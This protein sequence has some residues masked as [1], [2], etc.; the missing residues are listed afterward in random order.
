MTMEMIL[1]QLDSISACS[2]YEV[3]DNYI[4]LTI[5]DFAGF[6]SNW[7]EVYYS[8]A[9]DDAIDEVI[10]WL[11]DNADSVRGSLYHQYYFGE[12]VVE[13]G[14]TSFDI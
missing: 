7:N 2:D 8:D 6:D 13:V 14:Y 10:E 5:N 4:S 1:T 11:E 9:D 12:I 3:I